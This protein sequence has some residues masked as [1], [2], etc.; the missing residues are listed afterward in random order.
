MRFD[1]YILEIRKEGEAVQ[2]IIDIMK[3]NSAPGMGAGFGSI[4][5]MYQTISELVICSMVNKTKFYTA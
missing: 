2:K 3:Y 1:F 5:T 4:F